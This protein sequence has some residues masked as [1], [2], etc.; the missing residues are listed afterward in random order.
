M[1]STSSSTSLRDVVG[2]GASPSASCDVVAACVVEAV[3]VLA[4]QV[5]AVVTRVGA[6]YHRVDVVA[7]RD[8]LSNT[9]PG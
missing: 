4:K 5:D 1:V 8:P 3:V 2:S 7:A 6:A 9:T